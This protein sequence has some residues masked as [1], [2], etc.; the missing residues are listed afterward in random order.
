MQQARRHHDLVSA[1][2]AVQ[3]PFGLSTRP[4]ASRSSA[5]ALHATAWDAG[6]APF[7]IAIASV[8]NA[9]AAGQSPFSNSTRP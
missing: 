4:C 5:S 1:V 9:S 2:E 7:S 8:G 3:E 6:D